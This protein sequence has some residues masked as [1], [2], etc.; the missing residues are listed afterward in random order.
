MKKKFSIIIPAYNAEKTIEKC[1]ESVLSQTYKNFE[2]I[3]INDGSTDRTKEICK[4]Y[5]N[6]NNIIVK[7]KIIKN[8]KISYLK[9]AFFIVLQKE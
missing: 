4:K 2:I 6:E 1:I 5:T 7:A 3:V 9:S 8:G